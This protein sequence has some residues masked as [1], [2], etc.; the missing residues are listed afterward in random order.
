VFLPDGKRFL[1]W[2]WDGTTTNI[3][4]SD[5]D[6]GEPVLLREGS[7]PQYVE[8]GFLVFHLAPEIADE[9]Y[10]GGA[11][12]QRF[13]V[14]SGQLE[15]QPQPLF[16]GT[17]VGPEGAAMTVRDRTI[18]YAPQRVEETENSP[19]PVWRTRNGDAVDSVT[20][21]EAGWKMR[22]S[23]QGTKLAFTGARLWLHDLTRDVTDLIATDM[24]FPMYVSWSPDDDLILY[25][26]S[27]SVRVVDVTG[28]TRE[29]LVFQADVGA[30]A[31]PTWSPDGRT[32]L[33]ILQAGEARRYDEL[34]A[35]DLE[36]RTASQIPT[37]D[38][39]VLSAEFAPN[40]EWY[41]YVTDEVRTFDVYLRPFPGPGANIRVSQGGGAW[42]LW[43]G[44]GSELFYVNKDGRIAVVQVA[45]DGIPAVSEEQV[46]PGDPVTS[47]LFAR[48]GTTPFVVSPD[49]QR[50]LVR[51]SAADGGVSQ[52]V[53]LQDWKAM[54]E[55]GTVTGAR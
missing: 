14:G 27:R 12:V 21:R 17:G 9:S 33:F 31:A 26:R 44:D 7:D 6:G 24:V 23:H 32:V 45:F 39:N 40:G 52:L 55:D 16:S 22:L 41:A 4:R 3:Y 18:V 5:L 29:E 13:D 1:F 20:Y 38:Y 51:A 36:S 8:G 49:G 53:V 25:T 19:L 42:P 2:A 10:V 47:S 15:G 46:L 28:R 11:F 30:M 48:T 35:L 43:R 54:L 37:G 34:W 50:F